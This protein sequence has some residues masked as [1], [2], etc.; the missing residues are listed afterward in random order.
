M[1]KLAFLT[2]FFLATLQVFGQSNI[3][4]Y[5]SFNGWPSI[6]PVVV[7]PNNDMIICAN[8]VEANE[9]VNGKEG[10]LYRA[11]IN[12]D[13]IWEVILVEPYDVKK[14][15]L[16]QLNEES[17]LLFKQ[18]VSLIKYDISTGNFIESNILLS[19]LTNPTIADVKILNSGEVVILFD[20]LLGFQG[21]G[22]MDFG[23]LKVNSDLEQVWL[24]HY[25][26][27]GFEWGKELA[28]SQ[29]DDIIVL[30]RSSSNDL[31]I[32]ANYGS[33]DI[34]IC[35][36]NSNNGNLLWQKNYGGSNYESA[37]C[38]TATD[39]AGF[40][41][42]AHTTSND[43]DVSALAGWEPANNDEKGKWIFKIDQDGEIEWS[44]LTIEDC[45]F[46][47]T[48][49]VETPDG[50]YL[51]SQNNA[52]NGLPAISIEKIN[53]SGEVIWTSSF[54]PELSEDI[55]NIGSIQEILPLNDNLYIAIS[56]VGCYKN[57]YSYLTYAYMFEDDV[58]GCTNINAC[59]YNSGATSDDGSCNMPDCNGECDGTET[60]PI[61]LGSTCDDFDPCTENDVIIDNCVCQG[62]SNDTDQDGICDALDDCP[63]LEDSLIG[64]ACDDLESCTQNDVYTT[65]CLC[66]GTLID[67]DQDG[68]CDENDSCPGFDNNLIGTACDDFDPCTQN[69]IYTE[70]CLCEGLYVDF[71]L[72]GICDE[73]DDCPELDDSLIGMPCDDG[74][75][76]T[77]NDVFTQ[78]CECIGTLT[79]SDEDG[80]CDFDDLC[81]D[82][83]DSLIG[84]SCDDLD[85]CTE[86]DVYTNE[87]EC[88]GVPTDSDADGV[89]DFDDLCPDFDDGLIGTTCDDLDPCTEND[90]YQTSC[91]CLGEF[92]D[93]DFDGICDA[94][95]DCPELENSLIGTACN[96][97]D[98][99]TVNDVYQDNCSCAGELIDNDLQTITSEIQM[100]P[101]PFN[102]VLSLTIGK[103]I[104]PVTISIT[105]LSGRD[106]YSKNITTKRA[107]LDSSNWP[108]GIYILTIE[109]EGKIVKSQKVV[110]SD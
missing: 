77:E 26:G 55:C 75:N 51:L 103:Q 65:N 95:D 100:Y 50:N 90:S 89:C 86:N 3:V 104:Q 30:G 62:I 70:N 57:P 19:Q 109:M 105:D 17:V 76:C 54:P 82:F 47:Q 99:N 16:I 11:N 106:V 38:I 22:F 8:N 91:E 25:G 45:T 81:P 107:T 35:K 59:N 63:E 66:E 20:Y 4:D 31:D 78:E 97:G 79:D 1:K 40:V 21:N 39:D 69:D 101:N 13:I 60:G 67:D 96:D 94:L 9:T 6:N 85:P 92:A 29:D 58:S 33:S 72:D 80:V 74:E 27:S 48:S 5:T 88:V 93:T 28:V 41:I 102:N 18:G 64:T 61:P 53:G 87:C 83:D 23:L 110:K 37:K 2:S 24:N 46:D 68:I 36:V 15:H 49:I 7:L 12:G 98:P 71:D 34:S 44:N 32:T 56:K 14:L 84:T 43:F 52:G 73:L 108:N 42:V 10:T